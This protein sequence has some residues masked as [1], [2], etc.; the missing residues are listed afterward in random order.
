MVR[1]FREKRVVLTTRKQYRYIKTILLNSGYPK[2]SSIVYIPLAELGID[3]D[4]FFK[5][6]PIIKVDNKSIREKFKVI[7]IRK[8]GNNLAKWQRIINKEF[9]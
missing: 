3:V 2:L 6:L 9:M 4:I 8:S 7:D 5:G 1:K